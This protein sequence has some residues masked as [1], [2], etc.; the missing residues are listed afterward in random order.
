MDK[1]FEYLVKGFISIAVISFIAISLVDIEG[2][3]APAFFSRH[4]VFRVVY[5]ITHIGPF[6][7]LF[8]INLDE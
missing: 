7:G 4:P 6:D 3:C 1:L 8:F 2:P 5:T